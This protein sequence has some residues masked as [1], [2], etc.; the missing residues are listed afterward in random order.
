[1]AFPLA[2]AP[3]YLRYLKEVIQVRF[4][5]LDEARRAD[6]QPL[7]LGLLPSTSYKQTCFELAKMLRVGAV[8]FSLASPDRT[9]AANSFLH[10]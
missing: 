9:A 7:Q 3:A 5:R 1:M 8:F 6:V 2:H 10:C 4:I